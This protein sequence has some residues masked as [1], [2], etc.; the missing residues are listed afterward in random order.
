MPPS[1]ACRSI[2]SPGSS[3]GRRT[4]RGRGEVTLRALVRNALRM[5]PDRIVVGEV[6]G[7]EALDMLQAMNTGHD[8]SL[9]TVHASSTGRRAAADRDDGADGRARPAALRRAGAGAAAVDVV[10]H[11][12]RTAD[13]ARV[14]RRIDGRDR[15]GRGCGRSTTS[16][17]AGSSRR[18]AQHPRVD[19][20]ADPGV[21]RRA[22]HRPPAA[23]PTAARRLG[24]GR[25]C[26]GRP[27]AA[28]G[29]RRCGRR[30]ARAERS[31]AARRGGG[32]SL[33][34]RR[35]PRPS[36]HLAQTRM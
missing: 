17:W 10:V 6:R 19:D 18:D 31:S 13:G 2:T 4:S 24:A 27:V 5:R 32:R 7:G 23:G 35:R 26:P 28:S 36:A 1:C 21:D 33:S 30:G 20:C 29:R 14:V 11:L 15:T 25:I 3:R 12:V 34:A 9:T 22:A 16:S 8:G